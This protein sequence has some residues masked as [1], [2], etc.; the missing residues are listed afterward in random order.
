MF[1]E[2]MN[3]RRSASMIRRRSTKIAEDTVLS[4]TPGATCIISALNQFIT[5]SVAG[6]VR[7]Q[8]QMI[9]IETYPL[10]WSVRRLDSDFETLRDYLLRTYPQTQIPPL[11]NQTKKKLTKHQTTKRILYYQRFLNSILK[12]AVLKT[13]KFLVAFL[14]ETNQEAFNLKLLTIEEDVGPKN[15]YEF[16]TLTGEIE[17]ETRAKAAKFCDQLGNFARNYEK[18]NEQ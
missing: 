11:P 16:K 5:S 7:N 12:S 18:I 1:D 15:I 8:S 17:T 4:R 3:R 13:S 2:A 10:K 9:T 6:Y 14:Q